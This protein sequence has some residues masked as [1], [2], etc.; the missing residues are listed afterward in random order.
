MRTQGRLLNEEE[1]GNIIVRT[2]PDGSEVRLKDVAR[3]SSGRCST[4][5]SAATTARPSAVIA[6]F[7]IPG[8]NALDVANRSRRRWK[9]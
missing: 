6:V 9:T 4:T 3:S 7:Q 5:P 8:T 2:N 1:F